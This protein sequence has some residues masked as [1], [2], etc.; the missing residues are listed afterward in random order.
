MMTR[1]HAMLT[2]TPK[3]SGVPFVVWSDPRMSAAYVTPALRCRE[4]RKR[5]I[6]TYFPDRCPIAA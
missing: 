3:T 1:A 5:A 2:K 4:A 6:S